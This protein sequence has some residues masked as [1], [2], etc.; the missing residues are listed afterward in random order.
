AQ[1]DT[2]EEE[3]PQINADER[4]S[5]TFGKRA[6]HWRSFAFICGPRTLPASEQ[7]HPI[8]GASCRSTRANVNSF[9]DLLM[10]QH[11]RLKAELRAYRRSYAGL[12]HLTGL[13]DLRDLYLAGTAVTD[14]GVDQL[15]EALPEVQIHR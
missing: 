13:P 8:R 1:F 4:E 14:A 11:N 5:E 9:Q 12:E 10:D 15:K 3:Q 2:N 7:C 6:Y